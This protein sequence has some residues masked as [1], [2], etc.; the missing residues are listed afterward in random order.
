MCFS[1][2]QTQPKAFPQLKDLVMARVEDTAKV[3]T[4]KHCDFTIRVYLQQ[5]YCCP[6][7]V[8]NLKLTHM[9]NF[10]L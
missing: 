5:A 7:C 9:L 3:T 4:G 10:E 8:Q 6:K 1:P 2:G